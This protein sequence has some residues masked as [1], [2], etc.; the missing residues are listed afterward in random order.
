MRIST[1]KYKLDNEFYLKTSFASVATEW[2]WAW[3]IP[4]LIFMIFSGFGLW[5]WG[6]FTA[7][8]L[9][10]LYILFW[11]IQFAGLSRHEKTKM[12]F[13]PY[14]YEIDGKQIMMKVDSK[15]GMPLKWD[16]IA[17]AKIVKTGYL[18]YFN[19]FQF[20]YLPY[21]IFTSES[22]KQFLETLLKRKKKIRKSKFEDFFKRKPKNDTKV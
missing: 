22:Q 3:L 20:I 4:I 6:L 5:G 7:L 14:T 21:R 8:L 12:F 16:Q 11:I 2:W 9:T 15:R 17:Y 19:R 1:K 13:E 10:A 18:L